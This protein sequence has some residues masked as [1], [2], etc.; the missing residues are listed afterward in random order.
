MSENTQLPEAE[1]S[2]TTKIVNPQTQFEWLV[3]TRATS[4]KDGL[5]RLA[6]VEKWATDHGYLSFDAYVDQ[7]RAERGETS[8]P[9]NG[10]TPPIAKSAPPKAQTGET[11]QA[12]TMEATVNKGKAY[13]KIKGGKFAKFGVTI[14]PEVLEAAG[15]N[16]EELDTGE[17]Y[18]LAGYVASYSLKEDGKPEKVVKLERQ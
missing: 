17:S 11:F 18:S 4:A 14:W 6:L 12:E 9:T 16:L 13:W 15:F 8:K 2:A 10:A 5:P 7:R 1:F 3:T